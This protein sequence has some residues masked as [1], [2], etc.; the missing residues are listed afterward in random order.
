M[1][2]LI[3]LLMALVFCLLL[4]ACGTSPESSTVDEVAAALAEEYSTVDEVVAAL[5]EY[6]TNT[7]ENNKIITENESI[8]KYFHK[9]HI[10]DEIWKK[11]NETVDEDGNSAFSMTEIHTLYN[12]CN[13]EN[14]FDDWFE[15]INVGSDDRDVP[16]I[17]YGDSGMTISRLTDSIEN[18]FKDPESVSIKDAWVCFALP[19]GANDIDD[20]KTYENGCRYIILAEI[21]AKNSFGAYDS[22]FFRIEGNV[23]WSSWTRSIKETS[24]AID[25]LTRP[26]RID[27]Y[28]VWTRII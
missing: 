1:K 20:F 15:F 9:D 10:D 2:K 22:S 19:D 5:A 12:I 17:M 6:Y 7:K 11:L 16:F 8:C 26:S 4:C 27:G 25:L 18:K 24:L 3:A 23:H 28:G 21:S 13:Q 14:G